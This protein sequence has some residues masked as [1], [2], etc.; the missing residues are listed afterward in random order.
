MQEPKMAAPLWR[1]QPLHQLRHTE[2]VE[3]KAEAT[4]LRLAAVG[5]PEAPK[6][7]PEYYLK[8]VAGLPPLPPRDRRTIVDQMPNRHIGIQ[9]Q[10]RSLMLP[11]SVMVRSSNNAVV[12]RLFRY[13]PPSD[14][15]M[16]DGADFDSDEA[17]FWR[18][19][20][21]AIHPATSSANPWLIDAQAGVFP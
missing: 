13:K 9:S 18:R 2:P 7:P 11:T 4:A 10:R 14:M 3:K 8:K 5:V 21:A 19:E 15:G 6:Y 1:L 17:F 16:D 20:R 12:R